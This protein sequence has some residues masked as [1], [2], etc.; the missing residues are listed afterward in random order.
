VELLKASVFLALRPTLRELEAYLWELNAAILALE[1]LERCELV[2]NPG[3]K[4]A[5]APQ[6]AH[7]HWRQHLGEAPC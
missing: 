3:L 4:P 1:T 7:G 6:A 5:P 2:R